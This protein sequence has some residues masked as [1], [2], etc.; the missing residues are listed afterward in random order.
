ML[1]SARDATSALTWASLTSAPVALTT[2]AT[3]A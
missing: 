3:F 1:T 2:L